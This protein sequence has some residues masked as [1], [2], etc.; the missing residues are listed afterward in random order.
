M[1]QSGEFWHEGA[2]FM[3]FYGKDGGDKEFRVFN[4]FNDFKVVSD[5]FGEAFWA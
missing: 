5:D 3:I 4:D 1:C 2:D